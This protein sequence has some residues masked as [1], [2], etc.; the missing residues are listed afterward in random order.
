MLPHL[1]KN[2]TKTSKPPALATIV[3]RAGRDAGSTALIVVVDIAKETNPYARTSRD[4]KGRF[5]RREDLK[6]LQGTAAHSSKT[7]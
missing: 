3:P 1:K 6:V 4:L 2:R 7:W 5:C